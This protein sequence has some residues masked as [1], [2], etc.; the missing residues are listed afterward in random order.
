MLTIVWD[1]DDVLNDLMYQWFTYSW[2]IAHPECQTDYAGLSA[3]P[4]HKV[5]NIT[6]EEYLDSLDEFR[7]TERAKGMRPNAAVH[8]WLQNYG[9]RF[10]HVALT[11]R[12]LGSAPEVAHWVMSNFGAW[13]RCFG[14]VP[15]RTAGGTPTYDRNKG[16]F[17]RWLG[18]GDILVDDSMENILQAGSLGMKTLLY[19]QPWNDST[20]TA[21][22]LLEQLSRWAE[23]LD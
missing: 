10:R 13:V 8:A 4:P 3:N 2:V 7:K 18:C 21:D 23:N 1:V 9:D 12:P 20:L 14:V 19:P 15:T 16:E 17:L 5:L 11:A 6:R 22:T